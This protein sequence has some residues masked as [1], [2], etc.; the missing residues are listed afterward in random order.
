MEFKKYNSFLH[1]GDYNVEQWL[2]RPDVLSEDIRLMKLANVNVVTLG[3][4][5]WACLEP[6]EGIYTFEW[7]DQIM[8]AMH[9]NDIYVILATPSGGKPPWMVKKYPDIMRTGA[10]RVRLLYG[11]RE[12]QCNSNKVFR[13]KVKEID[14]LLAKRYGKHPALLMWHISNEMYGVCHCDDCQANFRDWL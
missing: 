3:V 7:L 13:S 5:S 10:N 14:E 9:K 2:D 6:K 1:G 12:N 4:F 11:D 8:D